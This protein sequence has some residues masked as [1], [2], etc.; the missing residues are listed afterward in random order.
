MREE[1]KEMGYWYES[2]M[3]MNTHNATFVTDV[4]CVDTIIATITSTGWELDVNVNDIIK[5]HIRDI[6]LK[7]I[8]I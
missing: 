5:S 4:Y 8:G 7:S 1:Y 2:N 3:I 6:K